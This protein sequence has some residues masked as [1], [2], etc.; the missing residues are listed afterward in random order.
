[1]GRETAPPE[2]EEDMEKTAEQET[3]KTFQRTRMVVM[4]AAFAALACVATMVVKVPSP[5]GGYMNLGDTVVLLGGYLLGPAWGALAGSIGPALADVLLGSPIYAPATLVI[6][7]G[8]AALAAACHQA[9][10][11]GRGPLGL[12]ACGIMGE[13][14]MVVGYW[15]YDALLL[16]S[17]AGAAAGIPSNLVQAAFGIA[18][19]TLLAA[20]LG[21]SAYVRRS[22]PAVSR[23]RKKL[24]GGPLARRGAL[25]LRENLKDACGG[26]PLARR[27]DP[28]GGRMAQSPRPGP[29]ARSPEREAPSGF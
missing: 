6:K 11:K 12:A 29:Q 1:M 14:P 23:N 16:G 20:A 17:A 21:R 3:A 28:E 15:L 26:G 19:S 22:S 4:A 7:A 9:F 10:G 2:G 5:T 18:A 27:P 8:M 24:P 13:L 25:R